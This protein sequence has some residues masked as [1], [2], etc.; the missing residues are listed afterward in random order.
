VVERSEVEDV[1]VIEIAGLTKQF[2]AGVRAV[3]NLT[4][5]VDHGDVC[6]LL[7]PNGAGKTTTLRMLVGLVQPTHGE[8]RVLGWTITPS[9]PVL[10]RVGTMI[11]HAQFVPYLTGR[12]NLQVYWEALGGVLEDANLSQA[13]S[14]AGLGDAIDRKV[15]TYSQG[16]RQRLGV[17]RAL[18]SA[19]EV[20]VLD[21]P[22]NGLDPGEMREIRSLLQR[23]GGEGVTVLLSSHLLSEVEQVCN[24][25]VVM[26]R[27]KL[28]ASGTIDELTAATTSAYLEVDDVGHA[29]LLLEAHPNVRSVHAD[30][31][32]ISVEFEGIERRD[33]V[34][35]L[36][37]RGVGIDT[38]VS[39]H[40]LEDAFLGL[41]EHEER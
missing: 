32:G 22:T 25:V 40:R 10:A 11:E 9:S 3:D 21:E 41:L 16:M 19:P 12:K 13:L 37:H 36:V 38:I 39:R 15:K 7:G 20:M 1:P 18:L 23:L 2:G 17:A 24:R 6:G 5:A 29:R 35:Y 30:P 27:G 4:F 31:P 14:V 34:A 33:L 26:D 28:I 8:G